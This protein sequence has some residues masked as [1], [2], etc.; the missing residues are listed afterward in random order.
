[1]YTVKN[2]LKTHGKIVGKV[3]EYDDGTLET[4]LFEPLSY[5]SKKAISY[6]EPY[7]FE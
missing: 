5:D 4:V 3:I 6:S 1:M 7:S 2:Y